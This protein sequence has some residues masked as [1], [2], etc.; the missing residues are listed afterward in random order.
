MSKNYRITHALNL[1][2]QQ[3][4]HKDIQLN[5]SEVYII[6]KELYE[7]YALE[8]KMDLF[9]EALEQLCTLRDDYLIGDCAVLD[10]FIVQIEKVYHPQ[11]K[12]K[13]V[14]HP[15]PWWEIERRR[16]LA[17][18]ENHSPCYVYHGPTQI[19]QAKHY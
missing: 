1:C 3:K 18:A 16:L 9:F 6:L 14:I 10:N 13:S 2:L 11:K 12:E 7:L 4:S 15:K 5:Q 8:N 19:S 17:I